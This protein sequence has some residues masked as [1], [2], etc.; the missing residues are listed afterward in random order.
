MKIELHISIIFEC[1]DPSRGSFHLYM[2]QRLALGHTANRR[3]PLAAIIGIRST[4][5]CCLFD[6]LSLELCTPRCR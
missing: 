5:K 6:T 4:G 2:Q 1:H 3:V